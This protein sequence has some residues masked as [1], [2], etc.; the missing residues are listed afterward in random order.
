MGFW[1]HNFSLGSEPFMMSGGRAL[2]DDFDFAQHEQFH[3]GIAYSRPSGNLDPDIDPTG[4]RLAVS[5]KGSA[6]LT[7]WRLVETL[8]LPASHVP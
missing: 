6:V 1:H 2:C 4:F 7:R 5:D 3:A 8:R